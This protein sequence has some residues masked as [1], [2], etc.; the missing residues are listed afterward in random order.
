MK[1][2][3]R[4]KRLFNQKSEI[5]I[6]IQN[7]KVKEI[8]ESPMNPRKR[9]EKADIEELAKN[10]AEQGL[11]QPITVRPPRDGM[12]TFE[13]IDKDGK[14]HGFKYEVVCGARRF[15]AINH[16][17]WK[18]VPAIVRE[19]TD[20]E[21]FDAMITENLQRKDVDPIDEAV[22]FSE[23]MRRGQSVKEL[24]ARF[25]KSERYIQD[26]TKLCGLIKELQKELTKGHI[27]LVGAIYLAKCDE[28]TQR[29]FYDDEIDGCFDDDD[30][31]C[32]PYSD[33][34]EF[35][36]RSF[37]L[38]ANTEW[39]KEGEEE[40]WNDEKDVPK[41]KG[42]EF[43]TASHGCLFYEMK[44]DA[45][46]TKE[47]CFEKKVLV[48]RKWKLMQMYDKMLKNGEEYTPDK[49]IV[50]E[51]ECPSCK[52]DDEKEKFDEA[53]E[54]LKQ[55]LPDV[56][57]MSY[58]DFNGSCYYKEDD[59]RLQK[60]LAEGKV[61]KTVRLY[62]DWHRIT[63]EYLYKGGVNR[64]TAEKTDEE[65]L[66]IDLDKATSKN[67]EKLD[68]EFMKICN[69]LT[70]DDFD[71]HP[72]LLNQIIKLM[73]FD[74]CPY[75][76]KNKAGISDEEKMDA[77]LNDPKRLS[78][79]MREAARSFLTKY[80]FYASMGVALRKKVVRELMPETYEEL[81]KKYE[82]KL[83]NAVEKIR[84]KYGEK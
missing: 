16:L 15:R 71:G 37:H 50:I 61:F 52:R 19:M 12:E 13:K 49:I 74:Y 47:S 63:I 39:M 80:S 24:A 75:I 68:G 38:L 42:C 59:E 28:D 9:F 18:E 17:G 3:K 10:I 78:E 73:V 46:C 69:E 20:A 58:R 25:G 22:A 67:T 29:S 2:R 82:E 66:K 79:V 51:S 23:L 56:Q 33:I 60:M 64:D 34:K 83:G 53:V 11:L 40:S 84:A 81:V 41:C 57:I 45:E 77:F 32:Y 27:P 44:G 4:H 43:N 6:E 72:E 36:T 55:S 21:A 65:L 31:D 14:A 5:M 30:T 48:F 62:E 76:F 70:N 54:F 7:L 8:C 35:V 26:R 1:R